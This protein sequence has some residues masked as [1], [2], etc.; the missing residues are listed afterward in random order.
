MDA[1]SHLIE[2]GELRD[3]PRSNDTQAVDELDYRKRNKTIC[4]IYYII[5]FHRYLNHIYTNNLPETRDTL[6]ELYDYIKET[7]GQEK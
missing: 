6:R 2:D 4:I 1:V 5:I 7:H 3:E